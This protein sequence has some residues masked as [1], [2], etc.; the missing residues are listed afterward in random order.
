MALNVHSILSYYFLAV[1]SRNAGSLDL[2]VSVKMMQTSLT[3]D[4][5]SFVKNEMQEIDITSTSIPESYTITL[6]QNTSLND[7]GVT[8]VV[9]TVQIQSLGFNAPFTLSLYDTE[10]VYI[11]YGA[12]AL[13][14]EAALND[15]PFLYPNLA[16]V[17]ENVAE[18]Y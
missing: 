14:V 2:E 16:R 11:N 10:T 17:T 4:K 13:E 18:G 8:G 15:L 12:T 9:Q 3:E 7:T 5:S 1:G 6:S